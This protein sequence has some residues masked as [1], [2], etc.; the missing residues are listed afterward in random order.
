MKWTRGKIA[1]IQKKRNESHKVKLCLKKKNITSSVWHKKQSN[2]L[3][4]K[5]LRVFAKEK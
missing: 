5:T 4:N 1:R 3:H 2:N